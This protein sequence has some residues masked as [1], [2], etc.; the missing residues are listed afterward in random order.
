M[1]KLH[2]LHHNPFP[3]GSAGPS[4]PPNP[5]SNPSVMT[6]LWATNLPEGPGSSLIPR[7]SAAEEKPFINASKEG[8]KPRKGKKTGFAREKGG[9]LAAWARSS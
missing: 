4:S 1:L 2:L 9:L 8:G 6:S 5:T 7:T 3:W